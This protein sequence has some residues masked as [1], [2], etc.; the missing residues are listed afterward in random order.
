M[1]VRIIVILQTSLTLDYHFA[2]PDQFHSSVVFFLTGAAE[3]N[4]SERSLPITEECL[5]LLK[6]LFGPEIVLDV[7]F[8]IFL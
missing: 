1:Q 6:V 8:C 4:L 7:C 2:R 3:D 5:L